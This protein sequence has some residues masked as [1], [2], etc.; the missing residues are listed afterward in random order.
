MYGFQSHHDCHTLAT[1]F[2]LHVDYGISNAPDWEGSGVIDPNIKPDY[3]HSQ[4]VTGIISSLPQ[5]SFPALWQ[6][7]MLQE[8]DNGPPCPSFLPVGSNTMRSIWPRPSPLRSS[9]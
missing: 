6:D 4:K 7:Q 8:A 9:T 2:K 1:C 5:L 3:I